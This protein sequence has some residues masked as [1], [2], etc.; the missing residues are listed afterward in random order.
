MRFCRHTRQVRI[1]CCRSRRVKGRTFNPVALSR[2][3]QDFC[4]KKANEF[5]TL[6]EGRETERLEFLKKIDSCNSSADQS[7]CIQS[8]KQK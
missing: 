8:L 7:R 3:T 1:G 4:A 5:R 2:E 6:F